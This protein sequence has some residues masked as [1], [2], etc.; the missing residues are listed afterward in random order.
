MPECF[1]QRGQISMLGPGIP[2]IKVNNAM[3]SKKFIRRH[4]GITDNDQPCFRIA[5]DKNP[6]TA[7]V[8]CV[9]DPATRFIKVLWK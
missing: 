7:A 8:L 4:G 2:L 9:P 1:S 6:P 3:G 5:A